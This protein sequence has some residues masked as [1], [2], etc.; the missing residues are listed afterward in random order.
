MLQFTITLQ[1]NVQVFSG[2]TQSAS[3]FCWS[4]GISSLPSNL[5]SGTIYSLSLNKAFSGCTNLS[6]ISSGAF[7]YT[8]SSGTQCVDMFYGCTSLLNVSGVV[9]PDI[10][11]AVNMFLNSG[12]TT[13]TS[14]LFPILLIVLLMRIAL[15]DVGI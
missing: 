5:F 14:S 6:S 8:V 3:S 10:R 11:S 15:V 7:N 13:I 4:S 1:N 9:I 12:L 2:R